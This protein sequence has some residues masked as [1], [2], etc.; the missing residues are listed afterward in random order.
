M[1]IVVQHQIRDPEA[2]WSAAGEALANLP[3]GLKLHH[4]LP[5]TDGTAA[6][7]LWEGESV[8]AVRDLL[9]PTIG[10]VSENRYYV[11]GEN[12][13]GLPETL[14]L[15]IS[16]V[17]IREQVGV[18][19][20]AIRNWEMERERVIAEVENIPEEHF[21]YAPAVGARTIREAAQHIVGAAVAI[22]NEVVSP[23]GHF[24]RLFDPQ[25]QAAVG[26]SLPAL[27]TKAEIVDA[28]RTTGADTAA[29]LR[30]VGEVLASRKIVTLAGPE[31]ALSGLWFAVAHEA[32]HRGQ[33]AVLARAVGEV[34]ALT[35]KI[36]AMLAR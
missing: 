25:V 31:T 18:V 9:E 11:V 7:C 15:D 36:N 12:A 22:A 27:G 29:Q 3:A 2:A 1:F 16:N 13:L 26:A 34:P 10:H 17:Q 19:E 30:A 8:E 20:E 5:N 32:S 14:F 21:D 24:G 28:L 4:S 35:Q 23:G 33:L 6:V